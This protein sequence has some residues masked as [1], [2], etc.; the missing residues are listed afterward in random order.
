MGSGLGA[1]RILGSRFYHAFS[2]PGCRNLKRDMGGAAKFVSGRDRRWP[3]SHQCTLE[4]CQ[5]NP[6]F[7]QRKADVQEGVEAGDRGDVFDEAEV[8]EYV[9]ARIDEVESNSMRPHPGC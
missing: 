8:W 6:L 1:R 4:R 5:A 3:P 2:M 7:E 9:D